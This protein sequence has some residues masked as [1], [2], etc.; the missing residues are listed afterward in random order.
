MADKKLARSSYDDY[1]ETINKITPQ[2][3]TILSHI[4]GEQNNL[5]NN[6]E[7]NV[8]AGSMI[9]SKKK[10]NNTKPK[11]SNNYN[12]GYSK[13]KSACNSSS[14]IVQAVTNCGKI[15]YGTVSDGKLDVHGTVG[16]VNYDLLGIDSVNGGRKQLTK[17]QTSYTSKKKKISNQRNNI[18][19]DQDS[20]NS[21]TDCCTD[22]GMN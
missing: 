16:E 3:K 4:S 2:L 9:K 19:N 8:A 21:E 18:L 22:F 15:V 10:N 12:N 1:I 13:K 7:K 5:N 6:L 11:T 20:L 14:D 17:K